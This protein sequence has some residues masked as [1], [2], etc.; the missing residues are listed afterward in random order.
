MLRRIGIQSTFKVLSS[1]AGENAARYRAEKNTYYADC[2][3]DMQK[4]IN[5]L[6]DRAPRL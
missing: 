5:A 3:E 1:L 6:Q 2:W 4:E